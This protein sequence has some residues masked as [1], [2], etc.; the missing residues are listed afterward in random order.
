MVQHMHRS[1][2]A[3]MDDDALSD[4]R[5]WLS[6]KF[7]VKP[8][9]VNAITAWLRIRAQRAMP[10][11]VLT[12]S[13][14]KFI[15]VYLGLG[16]SPKEQDVLTEELIGILKIDPQVVRQISESIR[17]KVRDTFSKTTSKDRPKTDDLSSLLLE[18]GSVDSL[19]G[20]EHVDYDNPT[21]EHWREAWKAYLEQHTHP[22]LRSHMKVLCLPGKHCLEVPLYLDLGFRK[23][24][25]VGIEGG[26][27]IARAEF[28]KNAKALGI[29]WQAMRLEEYLEDQRTR[30]DVVSLDFIGQLSPSTVKICSNLMLAER[31]I[32]MINTLARREG[33]DVQKNLQWLWQMMIDSEKQDRHLLDE[34]AEVQ[35]PSPDWNLALSREH[36]LA[37]LSQVG[38]ERRENW[39]YGSK[40][41]Q[42]PLLPAA[43]ALETNSSRKKMQANIDLVLATML[44]ELIQVLD[45]HHLVDIGDT[46]ERQV[47]A[48]MGDMFHDVVFGNKFITDVQKLSY[49]SEVSDQ[50]CTFHT[51][52]ASIH[53][54]RRLYEEI[55]GATEFILE[56]ICKAIE[57]IDRQNSQ[58]RAGTAEGFSFE[59]LRRNVSL[60]MDRKAHRSD[61]MTCLYGNK[62]ISA[63]PVFALDRALQKYHEYRVQ[64]PAHTLLSQSQIE[65][66]ELKNGD[67]D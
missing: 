38:V 31:S 52:I 28:E 46:R 51:D 27:R 59:I 8:G 54:P 29:D 6:E 66:Q 42:I 45:Q 17:D 20:G 33:R 1:E 58:N 67:I 60:P 25:I 61:T 30:F 16:A 64:N 24:N 15:K 57:M 21:K 40:I 14:A 47:L 43:Q 39:F 26:D 32:V 3:G 56:C 18:A 12:P 35:V 65:R 23:E 13:T 50:R 11:G 55:S 48:Q 7:D 2:I 53:T 62:V 9:R 4:E 49:R 19:H 44:G 10:D 22:D 41:E 36:L 63:C 5:R 34:G 37:A